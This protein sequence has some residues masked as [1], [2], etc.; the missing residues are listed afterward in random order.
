MK[1]RVLPWL[2]M[3]SGWNPPTTE[4]TNVTDPVYCTCDTPTTRTKQD[5]VYS[6]CF[7]NIICTY[8][9]LERSETSQTPTSPPRLN[10]LNDT[11]VV[12][13]NRDQYLVV[14]AT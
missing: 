9:L 11:N 5:I 1:P 2:Q 12:T 14:P 10:T 3:S 13:K 7:E 8:I 6:S 4:L